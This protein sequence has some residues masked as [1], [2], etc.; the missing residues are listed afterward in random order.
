[1]PRVMACMISVGTSVCKTLLQKQPQTLNPDVIGL[2]WG[3][4]TQRPNNHILTQNLYYN[5]YYQNP[6]YLIL[7]YLDPKP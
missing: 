2:G 3:V 6:E 5:Y 4:L 7:G 1:M